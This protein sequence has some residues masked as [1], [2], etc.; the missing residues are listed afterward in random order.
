MR[1]Y[2]SRNR[3]LTLRTPAIHEEERGQAR[4]LLGEGRE[5][6]LPSCMSRGRYETLPAQNPHNGDVAGVVS[7]VGVRGFEPPTPCS[8]SRC[9][10]GLRHTPNPGAEQYTLRRATPST[11]PATQQGPREGHRPTTMADRLLG[12]RAHLPE[13]RPERRI[14]ED[15][16]VAEATGTPS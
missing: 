3:A 15:R 16:V 6:A 7:M 11:C 2:F 14:V 13:A 5:C 1:L 8:Q 10:T 12:G 4:C 9:A